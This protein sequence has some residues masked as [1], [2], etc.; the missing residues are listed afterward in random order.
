V[1]GAHQIEK[2]KRAIHLTRRAADRVV[3]GPESHSSSPGCSPV[4]YV[5]RAPPAPPRIVDRMVGGSCPLSTVL[6]RRSLI[7]Q[8]ERFGPTGGQRFRRGDSLCH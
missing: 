7:M 2:M 6:I 4:R 3:N 1:K 5:A 8:R